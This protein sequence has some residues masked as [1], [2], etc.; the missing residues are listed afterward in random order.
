MLTMYI[1][2]KEDT[3]LY[4]LLNLVSSCQTSESQ[5]CVTILLAVTLQHDNSNSSNIL[6]R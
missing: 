2:N 1:K 6:S 3:D 5:T 4:G